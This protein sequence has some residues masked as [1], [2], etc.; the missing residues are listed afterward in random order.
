MPSSKIPSGVDSDHRSN[1]FGGQTSNEC[2]AYRRHNCSARH[3]TFQAMARC[4]WSRGYYSPVGEGAYV[5]IHDCRR[6]NPG[7]TVTLFATFAEAQQQNR[8]ECGGACRKAHK[9][10]RLVLA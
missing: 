7:G 4:I 1:L 9:V 5:A 2:V 10:V 6:P 8:W 3:R